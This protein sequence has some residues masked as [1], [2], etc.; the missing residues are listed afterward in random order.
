VLTPPVILKEGYRL[1]A[2]HGGSLMVADHLW[3]IAV[4]NMVGMVFS[5]VAGLVALR[6]LSSW[7]EHGRWQIFGYYCLGASLAV[8]GV[9]H[10]ILPQ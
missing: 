4:P 8:L 3:R 7:L 2:S 1:L 5:F 9:D 10:L 6:W